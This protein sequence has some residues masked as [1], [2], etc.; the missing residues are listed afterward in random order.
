MDNVEDAER[1]S[2]SPNRRDVLFAVGHIVALSGCSTEPG[3]DGSS[4]KTTNRTSATRSNGGPQPTDEENKTVSTSTPEAETRST[5]T[6]TRET[7]SSDPTATKTPSQTPQFNKSDYRVGYSWA[8]F[9]ETYLEIPRCL[10]SAGGT[11]AL[12]F[13][14]IN[15]LTEWEDLTSDTSE[16]A[17]YPFVVNT[18]FSQQS[19]VLTEAVLTIG[20]YFTVTNVS[21]IDTGKIRIEIEES[22]SASANGERCLSLFISL[23]INEKRIDEISIEYTLDSGNIGTKIKK[24]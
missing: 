8:P 20:E 2:E 17:D 18:D 7:T 5:A 1:R 9:G 10:L 15:T 16:V 11:S 13:M 12:R 14:L 4:E 6:P 21:G 19:I 23:P 3:T 24:Y 22:G